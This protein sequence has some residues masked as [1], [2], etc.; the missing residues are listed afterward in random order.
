LNFERCI[1]CQLAGR[2]EF[3]ALTSFTVSFGAS[4]PAS[5]SAL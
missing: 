1:W 2:Q 5:A 3:C 4:K